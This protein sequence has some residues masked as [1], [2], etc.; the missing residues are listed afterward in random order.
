MRLYTP[1]LTENT[2]VPH[3]YWLLSI[4]HRRIFLLLILLKCY[5]QKAESFLSQTWVAAPAR[6]KFLWC[7]CAHHAARLH[8]CACIDLLKK[9]G[10]W[11][12][13]LLQ[14]HSPFYALI[15]SMQNQQCMPTLKP[16]KRNTGNAYSMYCCN[17]NNTDFFK[18]SQFLIPWEIMD[19]L[20]HW[21]YLTEVFFR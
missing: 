10:Q 21:C 3:F 5:Q 15:I 16:S 12:E 1:P 11:L 7:L 13:D 8:I 19:G 14:G 6:I 4:C 20:C 18:E 17:L 2:R 9:T